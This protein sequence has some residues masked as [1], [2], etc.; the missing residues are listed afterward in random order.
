M[1]IMCICVFH[2]YIGLQFVA[3]TPA[4]QTYPFTGHMNC[5]Q[6]LLLQTQIIQLHCCK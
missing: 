6:K 1:E 4:V 2:A 5:T 3:I